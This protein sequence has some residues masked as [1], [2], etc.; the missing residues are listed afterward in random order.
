MSVFRVCVCSFLCVATSAHA[1]DND[2]IRVATYNV[3]LNR[4]AEGEL[5]H[6]LQRGDAQAMKVARVLRTIQPDIVLLNEFD[7]DSNGTAADLF[8]RRYLESD[9]R[10]L[11]QLTLPYRF[12]DSVNTGEPS[13]MDLNKNGSTDDPAD[14]FGFGQF[15]GQ[16][17]ML[18]LSRYP[19]DRNHVRTFR[20]LLWRDMPNAAAPIDAKTG[21]PWYPDEVWQRMRLSSKSHWDVPVKI[22]GNILHILTSH[23]T[24]PA[25]D[26]PED[27]NGRRNHDEIRFWAEYVSVD[28]NVEWICDDSGKSGGA[29]LND[30]FLILG[31]LNADPIDGGSHNHAIRQ[32]LHHPRVNSSFVPESDGAVAA[33]VEQ[34]GANTSH[35]GN[36]SHDTSDFSDRVVGNLRVDYVLPSKDLKV[37]AGAVVWPKKSEPLQD[38]INCSDHRMVWIDVTL[39]QNKTP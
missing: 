9:V 2:T 6:D 35:T 33:S 19:I 24:P 25:F 15:P 26:G 17:G 18:L 27:R 3:S 28:G 12:V 38:A 10:G 31:D 14:A 23:P 39:P 21:K 30:P 8:Q 1:T 22:G 29:K 16:Y 37:V 5:I 7:F 13:G 32:L 34:R 4:N 20:R 36:P 11:K